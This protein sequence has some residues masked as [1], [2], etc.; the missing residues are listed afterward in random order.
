MKLRNFDLAFG[1]SL[2][3]L[4]KESIH[5]LYYFFR[6]KNGFIKI[7]RHDYEEYKLKIMNIIENYIEK[8]AI[9]H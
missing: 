1:H 6:G 4:S 2:K 8:N 3:N 9:K 7:R 5:F